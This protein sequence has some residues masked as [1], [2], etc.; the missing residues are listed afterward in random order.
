M[1]YALLLVCALALATA[2]SALPVAKHQDKSHA[3][4]ETDS[5]V[6]AGGIINF[7]FGRR[8]VEPPNVPEARDWKIPM[9]DIVDRKVPMPFARVNGQVAPL[10]EAVF[11]DGPGKLSDAEL[12]H[13]LNS[14]VS[15]IATADNVKNT[16]ESYINE[17]CA[18]AP[19][20][21]TEV[22]DLEPLWNSMGPDLMN[23]HKH[24][25]KRMHSDWGALKT[26]F[27]LTDADKVSNLKLMDS[28][29]HDHQQ[30]VTF[31]E[32]NKPVDKTIVYK[33]RPVAAE[34][35]FQSDTTDSFAHFVNT[36]SGEALIP[37]MTIVRGHGYGYMQLMKRGGKIVQDGQTAT[38]LAAYSK[39]A[40]ATAAA[41]ILLGVADLHMENVM[42]AT[43]GLPYIID[44]EAMFNSNY[45][46][47]AD[48]MF[49]LANV[50]PG[51]TDA[52]GE[53]SV[54]NASFQIADTPTK[55]ELVS[56]RTGFSAVF[57]LLTT[58]KI[59]IDAWI[60]GIDD[61]TLFRSVPIST[62]KVF[63]PLMARLFNDPVV[64]DTKMSV[65]LIENLGGSECEADVFHWKA[66]CAN[67]GKSTAVRAQT[68][69]QFTAIYD[70]MDVPGFFIKY[71]AKDLFL[72]GTTALGV[73]SLTN[74]DTSGDFFTESPKEAAQARVD[75]Y[76][77]TWANVPKKQA[78]DDAVDIPG[79]KTA[80]IALRA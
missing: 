71:S 45:N 74:L 49:S 20:L 12:G 6:E 78:V 7:F 76:A 27:G 42:V 53:G 21:T 30:R 73:H 19:G 31:I 60:D 67:I 10:A 57:D 72:L 15:M 61:A 65:L 28:D 37:K 43:D 13:L 41:V 4:V 36:E 17:L 75:H 29:P 47:G 58:K 32:F 44:G 18:N 52:A 14:V 22:L 66:T 25:L 55:P 33:P 16:F 34:Y 3:L 5:S 39:A 35:F 54:D 70:R 38:K 56:F 77:G 79:L 64:E 11:K 59:E 1:K 2:I 9:A 63:A 24:I 80:I 26:A 46:D 68:R 8:A 48:R 50:G 62:R 40:G 23:H 69:D 51:L